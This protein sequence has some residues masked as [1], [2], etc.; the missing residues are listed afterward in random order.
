M[1]TAGERHFNSMMVLVLEHNPAMEFYQSMG[2]N[3]IATIETSMAG[4]RLVESVFGWEDL[5]GIF[6]RSQ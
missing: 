4:T 5:Q 3:K 2:G 6:S 1:S